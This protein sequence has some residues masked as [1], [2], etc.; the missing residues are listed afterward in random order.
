ME[1][2]SEAPSDAVSPFWNR[3][4]KRGAKTEGETCLC[5]GKDPKRMD[6]DFK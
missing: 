4:V 6:V 3:S 5:A 1:R 2:L